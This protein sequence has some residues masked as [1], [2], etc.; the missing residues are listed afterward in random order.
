M[1]KLRPLPPAYNCAM[2]EDTK[3][4]K[5]CPACEARGYIDIACQTCHGQG[6]IA[7]GDAPE[8]VCSWCYEPSSSFVEATCVERS[9]MTHGI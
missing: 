6:E 1:K 2:C 7:G 5:D 3:G 9:D 8:M 4:M